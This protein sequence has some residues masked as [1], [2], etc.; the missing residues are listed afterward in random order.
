MTRHP[1]VLLTA[2]IPAA[3]LA[4]TSRAAVIRPGGQADN[5]FTS[6]VER[7]DLAGQVIAAQKIP[8]TLRARDGSAV[9]SLSILNDVIRNSPADTPRFSYRIMN[10]DGSVLGIDRVDANSF[11]GFSS[12][13]FSLLAGGGQTA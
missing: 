10:D 12:D 1:K 5:F 11:R 7:P 6:L 9:Y 13:V 3:T 4:A 8:V 2:L